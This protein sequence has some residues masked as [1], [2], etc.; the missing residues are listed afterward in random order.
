[1]TSTI[2][3]TAQAHPNHILRSN[4]SRP[5]E[6]NIFLAGGKD[7]PEDLRAHRVEHFA[8]RVKLQV[9]NRFEHF[10]ATTEV[11]HVDGRSLRVYGWI[12]RTYM[13]E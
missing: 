6:P 4:G 1:M 7:I 2:L 3:T 10:E 5:A 8:E 11:R 13:A 9:E 12:Y